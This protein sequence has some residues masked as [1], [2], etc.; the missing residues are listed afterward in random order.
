M[1]KYEVNTHELQWVNVSYIVEAE[2]EEEARDLVESGDANI[3]YIDWS[4]YDTTDQIDFVSIN[5]I[6]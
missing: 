3:E 2:S 6:N 1:K 4:E 5:E